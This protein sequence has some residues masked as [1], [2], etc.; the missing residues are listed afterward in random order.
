MAKKKKKSTKQ[1]FTEKV[2]KAAEEVCE[3][4]DFLDPEALELVEA[5]YIN[6][7]QECFKYMSAGQVTKMLA[8]SRMFK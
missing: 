3:A 2:E 1:H 8:E 4:N 7:F 6:A 5:V